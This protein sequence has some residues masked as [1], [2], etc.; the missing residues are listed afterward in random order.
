MTATPDNNE[1]EELP[2]A[3]LVEEGGEA[4]EAHPPPKRRRVLNRR[5]FLL[6][7]AAGALGFGLYKG[8][9]EHD[10]VAQECH[11]DHIPVKNGNVTLDVKEF[12]RQI[13]ARNN[14]IV[15]G[16][17]DHTAEE[18]PLFIAAHVNDLKAA[19][20][21]AIFIEFERAHQP[22]RDHYLRNKFS[23][24]L[25]ATYD[26]LNQECKKHGIDVILMDVDFKSD[27]A[28]DA[29]VKYCA[30]M[31]NYKEKGIPFS[32]TEKY[33]GYGWKAFLRER[34]E[35]N[36]AWV[37]LIREKGYTKTVTVCGTHHTSNPHWFTPDTDEMIAKLGGGCVCMNI[38][39]TDRTNVAIRRES[40]WNP[41]AEKPEFTLQVAKLPND[42][43]NALNYNIFQHLVRREEFDT[44]ME[45]DEA[46]RGFVKMPPFAY[47]AMTEGGDR[48]YYGYY[49]RCN[50]D[51]YALFKKQGHLDWLADEAQGK[52]ILEA[53][54][55][56]N[57][58][59][60]RL[61]NPTLNIVRADPA[62]MTP[63]MR[64]FW[65]RNFP[66][67]IQRIEKLNQEIKQKTADYKRA[68]PGAYMPLIEFIPSELAQLRWLTLTDEKETEM[69]AIVD[70]VGR[71]PSLWSPIYYLGISEEDQK[72]RLLQQKT[73]NE[74][75]KACETLQEAAYKK[76]M[77]AAREA[78]A[79]MKNT[80]A[81][82]NRQPEPLRRDFNSAA[83]A[84]LPEFEKQ[85]A[86]YE[87]RK[88]RPRRGGNAQ[89][90]IGMSP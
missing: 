14:H 74:W 16:D 43:K 65:D 72:R 53:Y 89:N 42:L 64:C 40:R 25:L 82:I 90:N 66:G 35:A 47:I 12:L 68:H 22:Y 76:D 10:N 46:V 49:A 9:Q 62:Q 52:A 37:D 29:Y 48:G 15:F 1:E 67:V 36:A 32:N 23:Y 54:R 85:I 45:A 59:G 87:A 88:A 63:V 3:E 78:I 55:N 8:K 17:T 44:L 84:I 33:L 39:P 18:I 73:T 58:L 27:A 7:G 41:V 60:G 5:N 71:R 57:R 24:Q 75:D 26:Y 86:L 61:T 13:Y 11:I 21:Q 81:E 83:T 31:K 28:K 69:A 50:Y 19:G 51:E 77:R 2:E 70:R 34:E 30:C 79:A 80:I 56:L 4:Q 6:A 20:A 38:E